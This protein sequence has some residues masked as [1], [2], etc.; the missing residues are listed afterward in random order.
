MIFIQPSINPIFLSIGYID[1]RWYS[2]AYIFAFIF[3]SIL[4]KKLNKK[5]YNLL[6]GKQIDSFLIWAVIG[7]IIG[8]RFG[9]VLFYQTSLFFSNPY[10]IL[11]IW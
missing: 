10:Y 1:I 5:S 2:M 6:S 11:D 8:G 7:V 9:Y 4:I 3:G